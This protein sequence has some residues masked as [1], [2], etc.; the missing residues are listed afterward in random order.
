MSVPTYNFDAAD[1]DVILRIP[2]EPGSGQFKDFHVHK[3]ILSIASTSFR[4]MLSLLQPP[5]RT[6]GGITLPIIPV[7]ESAGVF[8]IFLRLIYPVEPPTVTSLQ[9]VDSLFQLAEKYTTNSVHVKLRRILALSPS[10][11]KD[12]PLRVYTIACRENLDTEAELAIPLTFKI[13]II[14]DIP[15]IHLRMMTAETYNRLLIAH[16]TRRAA[17]VSAVNRAKGPSYFPNGCSCGGWFY[18]RLANNISLAIWE[19]PFLDR[20]R[21]DSC[22]SGS[23]I[24][25]SKCGTAS[26]RVSGQAI[27]K[28]FT[29]ILDEIGKLE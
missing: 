25:E 8:E 22:L 3:G 14:R 11:L 7:A 15:Q 10:F 27:S 18:K 1:A 12:D 9:L 4:D 24:K 26:C 13:D 23:M 21:F 20:Q 2:H 5:Q 6:T 16:S 19:R 17:L 29:N 28:Y